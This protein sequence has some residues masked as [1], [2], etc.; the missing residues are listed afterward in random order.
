[1]VWPLA[2]DRMTRQGADVVPALPSE[3]AVSTTDSV[4]IASS[5]R[6]VPVAE[7]LTR[8]A[9]TAPDRFRVN[10]SSDSYV[11]SPTTGTETVRDVWPG[12][13]VRVPLVAVKSPPDA[14][15]PA[16]VA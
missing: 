6:M 14:A 11:A 10:V 15:V 9:L 5:L 13:K 4:G 3:T 1:M 16:A 2:A 7:L 8:E 12:A